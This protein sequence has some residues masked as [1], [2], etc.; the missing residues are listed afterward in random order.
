L[1]IHFSSFSAASSPRDVDLIQPE[2]ALLISSDL[3]NYHL[4]IENFNK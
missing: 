3:P 4:A 1:T 2:Q